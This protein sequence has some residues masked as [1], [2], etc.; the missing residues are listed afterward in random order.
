MPRL[1]TTAVHNCATGM[2]TRFGWLTHPEPPQEKVEGSS[3]G[4]VTNAQWCFLEAARIN[5]IQ[6]GERVEVRTTKRK[7]VALW[8]EPRKCHCNERWA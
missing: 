1:I 3:Y 5:G 8:R 7:Q 4:C 6:P 2:F